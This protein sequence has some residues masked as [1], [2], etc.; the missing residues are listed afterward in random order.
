MEIQL[1]RI[2]DRLIHGQ[3]VI[4]WASYLNSKAIVLCDDSVCANEWEKELYLSIVPGDLKASVVTIKQLAGQLTN[5]KAD[6]SK[7]IILMSS[8]F[9]LEQLIAEGAQ[10][11]RVNVGGIHF[12]EGRHE[13]LPYLYLNEKE[14]AAFRHLMDLGV[15]FYC[16][17]VPSAKAIPL[18]KILTK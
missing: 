16:Q 9:A 11:K 15:Y 10:V 1:F 6:F 3:V 5:G 2:D 18:Q 17:D 12:K 7:T 14:E 8:P 13:L 4:G